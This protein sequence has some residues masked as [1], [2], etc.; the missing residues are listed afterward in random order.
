MPHPGARGKPS[1]AAMLR[2]P[3]PHVHVRI[4]STAFRLIQ[5]ARAGPTPPS[6]PSS[7]VA[8]TWIC[9]PQVASWHSVTKT[10]LSMSEEPTVPRMEEWN[11][12]T[13]LM[14]DDDRQNRITL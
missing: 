11:Y 6:A 4:S 14:S 8:M 10:L 1:A 5:A 3:P 9:A 2:S 12:S 13:V 7:A